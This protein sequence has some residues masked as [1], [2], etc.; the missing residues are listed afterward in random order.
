ML[1][2]N[3]QCYTNTAFMTLLQCCT[4]ILHDTTPQDLGD[5]VSAVFVPLVVA[6]SILTFCIWITL[7]ATGAVPTSWYRDQPHAPSST[8]FSFMFALAVL[9]I[10]CPCAVGLARCVHSTATVLSCI[11]VYA[12]IDFF[13]QYIHTE[14]RYC[15]L[16]CDY[17]VL[18]T[19]V[20]QSVVRL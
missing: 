17:S 14:Y 8:L 18:V 19:F 3:A 15:M 6:L 16:C 10:A 13:L 20:S 7:T 5:R 1:S 2:Y 12:F 11:Y 9:V 4:A